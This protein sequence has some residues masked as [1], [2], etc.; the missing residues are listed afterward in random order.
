MK[1]CH[2]SLLL[3]TLVLG[4]Q[5]QLEYGFYNGKC[6]DQDVETII[7]D[8]VAQ[9]FSWDPRIVAALLRLMFHD[10]FVN[11]C[12]ASI[13]LDGPY[14]EKTS[15]S[16][17]SVFGYDLIDQI[18]GVLENLCPGVVSCSDIIVAATRDAT[19]LAGGD[20]FDVQLGRRDGRTSLS[21]LINLPSKYISV[22]DSISLFESKGL[23]AFD[24]VVLMGA[25]TV[26]ATYCST[27]N[28]RL[29]NYQG[30]GNPDPTM[31]GWYVSVLQT[32]VC[33]SDSWS[34]N[35]VFLDD[36]WSWLQVDN[37][38]YRQIL[39]NKGTLPIDQA[40]ANDGSTNGIV[41]FLA[42]SD[43]FLGLFTQA[44]VKLGGV[45]VLTGDQGEIRSVCNSV[46]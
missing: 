26:G 10:C 32:Y 1:A 22:Q 28:D 42:Y 7:R 24:M 23:S 8:V 31:D 19:I 37:S 44:L 40:L 27:I 4:S 16:N 3:L 13:L 11:G 9:R 46:N 38:Y 25:H 12:D 2:L 30:S 6:S 14:S 45:E 15:D 21:W 18:K 34:D 36:P 20:R 33:P 5:A 39:G 41:Q 17:L 35:L 43:A 29:Y